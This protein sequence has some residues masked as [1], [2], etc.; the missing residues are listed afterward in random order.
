MLV[1][2]QV[3]NSNIL[4]EEVDVSFVNCQ[5]HSFH[6]SFKEKF[7]NVQEEIQFEH[8]YHDRYM[9]ENLANCHDLVEE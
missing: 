8:P 7:D 5:K 2:N 4:D 3:L 6:D 9:T 1:G